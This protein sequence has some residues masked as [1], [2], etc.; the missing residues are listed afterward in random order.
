MKL[1]RLPEYLGIF[2][3]LIIG[4]FLALY[5]GQAA[6]MG[7]PTTYTFVGG[8]IAALI[9]LVM[10]ANIWLLIP[11]CWSLQGQITGLP[12]A[13]PVRDLAVLYAFGVFLA[14][15]ALKVIRTKNQYNW[16]DVML[17]F[18]VAYLLVVF[19]RNPVGTDSIGSDRVGGKPYF[20]VLTIL[21]GYWV[22][23]H[24]TISAKQALKFPILMVLGDVF[25]MVAGFLTFHIPVLGSIIGRFY[26]GISA[27]NDSPDGSTD[28]REMFLAGGSVIAN[29]LYSLYSPFST[30]NP[31][32]C[33]RFLFAAIAVISTLKAGY[34]SILM[35]LVCYFALSVYFRHGMRGLAKM[36]LII[37]PLASVMIMGQGRIFNL[38]LPMQRALSF[39]PGNWEYEAVFEAEKST[40]WRH[41]I[42]RTVWT[43]GDR[44]I[45]DWWFGDGFGMTK[46]QFQESLRC[47]SSEALMICGGYHSLPL[48]AIR[49]VGYVGFVIFCV[50]LFSA[51]YY[52]WQLLRRT[53]GTAFFPLAL[54]VGGPGIISILPTLILTGFFDCSFEYSIFNIAMLR[55]ISRSYDKHLMEQKLSNTA[56][57]QPLPQLEFQRFKT[58]A[59]FV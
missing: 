30:L 41:N 10:R 46:F 36:V 19:I 31:F 12:G 2:V 13:F 9:A 39:V 55:M 27:G 1:D 20:E 48:S 7:S 53:T 29:A 37:M 3:T 35:N 26:N 18:N 45:S 23:G 50:L 4:T 15:K 44:Y 51:A 49:T 38:P 40:E 25:T 52:A 24:V 32:Y 8:V 59:E 21:L 56:P 33:W 22:I 43:S 42:W 47:D 58:E 28:T 6:G 34:R 14:L 11:I 17:M 5:L 16:L 54:F 57:E